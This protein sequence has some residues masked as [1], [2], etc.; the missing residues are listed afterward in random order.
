M[1][2][3]SKN[4]SLVNFCEKHSQTLPQDLA[5]LRHSQEPYDGT[6]LQRDQ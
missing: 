6:L 4:T 3:N 5:F 1:G 2:E